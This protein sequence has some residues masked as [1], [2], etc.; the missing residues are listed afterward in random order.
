[1]AMRI[2][3]GRGGDIGGRVETGLGAKLLRVNWL[4]AALIATVGCVGCL[5]LYSVAGG[6]LDPWARTQIVRFSL[7]FGLML[8]VGLIDIRFWRGLAAPIYLGVLAL[9]VLV[10]VA[11]ATGQGATRWLKIGSVQL[12]PS[13]MMKVAMVLALARY[14]QWLPRERVSRPLWIL[15]PLA[16]AMLPALLVAKQPDLGTALMLIAGAGV[17][18]F[19]AGVSWWFFGGVVML[20]GAG[21]YAVFASRGADWQLLKDYQFR[22]IATFLDPSSDPLGAGYHITQSTIAIGSGGLN[23]KGFLQGPQTHLS[24]LPESETDF[25]FTSL[26][27]EF[28]FRGCASLL[29]LYMLIVLISMLAAARIRSVFGRLLAGGV[30]AT[31]FFFFA[32]N[33]AMVTGMAPV[34]GVPLPLISFGGTSMLSLLFAF[35][36]LM[37]AQIHGDDDLTH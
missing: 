5:M 14:Y 2:S 23:G 32:I 17:V 11:G 34:V 22:R 37:S 33:I 9:L 21:V 7:G 30:A 4:L 25:I 28:G 16:L 24:F 12:Q 15:A 1:M 31:F 8:L 20:C 26:A 18:M 19:L 29:G 13:E 27:E 36:L 6:S 35:G 10:E 3:F